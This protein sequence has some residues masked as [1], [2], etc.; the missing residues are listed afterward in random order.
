MPLPPRHV[1]HACLCFSWLAEN[2][3]YY[4]SRAVEATGPLLEGARD[5]MK[6]AALFVA[7]KSSELFLWLQENVPLVIE[8][9]RIY[10]PYPF[11]FQI[12]KIVFLVFVVFFSYSCKY[13]RCVRS[14]GPSEHSRQRV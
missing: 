9:V 7:Q 12:I 3:P 4:Y 6:V 8:W 5:R 14:L 1:T 11:I 10:M 2:T 13:V